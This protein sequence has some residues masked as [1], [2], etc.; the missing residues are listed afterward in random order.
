MSDTPTNQEPGNYTVKLAEL[1]AA[2]KVQPG[3]L[4]H[5]IVA[6]DDWCGVFSGRSCNCDPDVTI[7]PAPED[8]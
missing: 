1:F 8:N 4:Q 3:R 6:H 7:L 2:G 5:A